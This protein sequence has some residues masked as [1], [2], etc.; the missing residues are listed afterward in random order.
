MSGKFLLD[1]NIVIALFA[2]EAKVLQNL[3]NATDVFLSVIILGELYYGAKRSAKVTQN[4]T[5]IQVFASRVT[6]LACDALTAQF[7]GDVKNALRSKGQPIPENDI[8]LAATALQHNL[9]LVTRDSHFQN[10]TGLT[11]NPW[12]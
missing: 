9:T 5:T 12:T 3:Q 8:W 11:T 7:Y 10:V 1:T 6:L 4:L 2:N